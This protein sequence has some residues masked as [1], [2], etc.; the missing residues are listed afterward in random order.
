MLTRTRRRVG[1][2]GIMML[3]VLLSLILPESAR[4]DTLLTTAQIERINRLTIGLLMRGQSISNVLDF[5]VA[6]EACA[7]SSTCGG[8]YPAARAV[9]LQ[10]DNLVFSIR[11]A[12]NPVGAWSIYESFGGTA[13]SLIITAA[14][15][16]NQAYDGK[17]TFTGGAVTFGFYDGITEGGDRYDFLYSNSSGDRG[18]GYVLWSPNGCALVGPFVSSVFK[19]PNGFFNTGILVLQRC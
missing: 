5:D 19:G 1:R 8:L 11:S 6:L 13:G 3:L 16:G 7:V 9:G 17:A 18:T 2:S 12:E 15:G 14:T 10:T 4:A